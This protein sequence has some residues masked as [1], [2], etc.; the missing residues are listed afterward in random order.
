MLPEIRTRSFF[1]L[2]MGMIVSQEMSLEWRG[3]IDRGL[4]FMQAKVCEA[5]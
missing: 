1:R 5:V 2:F 3:I 4:G